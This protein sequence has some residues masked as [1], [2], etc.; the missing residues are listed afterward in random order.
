MKEGSQRSYSR[1]VFIVEQSLCFWSCLGMERKKKL[2][3]KVNNVV[4]KEGQEQDDDSGS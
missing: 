4:L 1:H 2:L 3:F